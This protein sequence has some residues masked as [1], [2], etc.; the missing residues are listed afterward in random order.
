MEPVAI[1]LGANIGDRATT[2]RTAVRA[3][4]GL[5]RPMRVSRVYETE[6]RHNRN[7][8]FFLNAAVAGR[9]TLSPEA[10]LKELQSLEEALGRRRS[11]PRFGPRRIDLDVLFF[12]ERMVETPELVIPHPRLHE[13][14]FVLV[15]LSEIVPGWRFPAGHPDAGRRID[16]LARETDRSGVRETSF[17]LV[18]GEA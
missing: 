3:I 11:G 2:L 13:R 17:Q 8:P 4:D 10:L 5:L 6:P 16:E 7:Q 14:A 18:G 1:G 12:G 15:P 9:T